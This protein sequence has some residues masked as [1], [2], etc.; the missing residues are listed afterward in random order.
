MTT[1]GHYADTHSLTGYEPPT[2]NLWQRGHKVKILTE[3]KLLLDLFHQFFLC[4]V[5]VT[6]T[7][8]ANAYNFLKNG[9]TTCVLA[10]ARRKISS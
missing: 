7:E 1:S 9:R 8:E 5:H 6:S 10:G 4:E 2:V 3:R